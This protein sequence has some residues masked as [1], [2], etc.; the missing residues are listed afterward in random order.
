VSGS[1][2]LLAAL[3]TSDV[4]AFAELVA[5]PTAAER[6]A[7]VDYLGDERYE[8]MRGLALRRGTRDDPG[9]A[10]G[11]VVVLH[12]LMGSELEVSGGGAASER[13]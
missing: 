8:R 13:V 1:A 10:R 12:G 4:H 11:N 7:L 5:R 6:Q 3:T 2:D 9:G